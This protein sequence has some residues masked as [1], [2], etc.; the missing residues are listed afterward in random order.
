MTAAVKPGWV[1]MSTTVNELRPKVESTLKAG[2]DPGVF[3]DDVV[4]V[5]VVVV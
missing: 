2:L 1:A 5:V 4:V 3:D